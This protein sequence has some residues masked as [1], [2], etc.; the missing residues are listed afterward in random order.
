MIRKTL[1]LNVPKVKSLIGSIFYVDPSPEWSTSSAS[2]EA[3]YYFIPVV[4]EKYP[5]LISLFREKSL[6]IFAQTILPI[7]FILCLY[8]I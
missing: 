5:E 7:L 6:I 2:I 3:M 1:I 4:V 8:I